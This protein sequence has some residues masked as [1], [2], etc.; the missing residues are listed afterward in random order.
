MGRSDA[1]SRWRRDSPPSRAPDATTLPSCKVRVCVLGGGAFAFAMASAVGR[2][3]IPVT[4]LTRSAATVELVNTKGQA[5]VS[6]SLKAR[7]PP[8]LARAR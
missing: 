1:R 5:A 6:G 8:S 4:V 3:G 2:K 7:R